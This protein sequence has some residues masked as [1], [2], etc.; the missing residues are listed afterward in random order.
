MLSLERH[1]SLDD[2]LTRIA[3]LAI[4]LARG[5]LSDSAGDTATAVH[6]ARKR[7]K[8][9]RAVLRLGRY[10]L[11]GDFKTLNVAFRDT[12]RALAPAREAAAL[13]AMAKRLRARTRDPLERRALTRVARLLREDSG[14]RRGGLSS[15][16]P[17]VSFSARGTQWFERGLCRVYRDG[18]R[19]F[20][21]ARDLRTA[22]AIHEWRKRVKDL[23]YV[24]EIVAPAWPAVMDPRAAMLHDLSRLLGDHHDVWTLNELV[25][26]QRRRF[27]RFTVRRIAAIAAR[28]LAEIEPAAFAQGALAYADSPRG[29]S[30]SVVAYWRAWNETV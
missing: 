30:G 12:A 27:G 4:D 25:A 9:I 17:D 29:W 14:D 28:R 21:Q 22:A 7:F 3:R 6:E 8:E 26:Q 2:G 18:R 19:A 1:E 16:L 20:R 5:H 11:D 13:A 15:T 23:W 24:T 10:G